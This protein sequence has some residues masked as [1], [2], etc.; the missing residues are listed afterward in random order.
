MGIL[1]VLAIADLASAWIAGGPGGGG[2]GCIE[3][4]FPSPKVSSQGCRV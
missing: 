1:G 2:G 3:I 4:S